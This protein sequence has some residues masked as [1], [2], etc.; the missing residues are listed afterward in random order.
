MV[1]V[2]VLRGSLAAHQLIFGYLLF[3]GK[4]GGCQLL[5]LLQEAGHLLS[6]QLG[7]GLFWVLS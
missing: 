3:A 5:Q 4:G 2:L 1:G 7:S 6:S